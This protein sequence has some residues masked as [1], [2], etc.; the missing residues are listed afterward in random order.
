MHL[1]EYFGKQSKMKSKFS[2]IVSTMVFEY[3]PNPVEV[4][5]YAKEVMKKEAIGIHFL[6][7]DRRLRCITI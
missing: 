5:V 4:L 7:N 6:S 1:N 2:A 3:L